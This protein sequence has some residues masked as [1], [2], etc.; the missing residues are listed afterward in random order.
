MSG[1]FCIPRV[2]VH[3]TT[4][5]GPIAQCRWRVQ[6][7]LPWPLIIIL[8]N[9]QGS[10]AAKHLA[11]LPAALA[12]DQLARDGGREL[13]KGQRPHWGGGGTYTYIYICVF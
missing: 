10:T 2:A 7:M 4:S 11:A 8:A 6:S 3:D 1:S 5:T 12:A 9:A 13:R